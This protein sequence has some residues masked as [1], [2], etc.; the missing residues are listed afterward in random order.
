MT[1]R[2]FTAAFATALVGAFAASTPL[3]AQETVG[4]KIDDAALVT[5][6]KSS[7]LSSSDVDGLDVNVDVEAVDRVLPRQARIAL[8]LF[9]REA[10]QN[11]GR[12]AGASA[13]SVR[14]RCVRDRVEADVVVDD[15]GID[16]G[17]SA[18]HGLDLL[19]MEETVGAVGGRLQVARAVP[20]GTQVKAEIPI[21]TWPPIEPQRND[22]ESST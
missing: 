3:L 11:V 17:D 22:R 15:R 21:R 10:L 8:V 1:T 12:H 2:L 6:I 9:V 19:W 20:R 7:L 4:A 14:V 13:A 18:P 5:K 16:S